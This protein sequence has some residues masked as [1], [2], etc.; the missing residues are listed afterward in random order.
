MLAA[1]SVSSDIAEQ[2]DPN[3][4]EMT[5]YFIESAR[6]YVEDRLIH[7]PDGPGKR[8]IPIEEKRKAV[9]GTCTIRQVF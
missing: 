5:E 6:G 8:P 9:R 7:K 1:R 3:F 2:E 4:H